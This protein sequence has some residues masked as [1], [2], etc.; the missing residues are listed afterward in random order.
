MRV[1]LGW[2][3]TLAAVVTVAIAGG[4]LY[5]SWVSQTSTWESAVLVQSG[6]TLLLFV[7][8]VIVGHGIETRIESVRRQQD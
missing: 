3:V 8:L 5:Y 1:R 6:S 7:P 4:L 2:G